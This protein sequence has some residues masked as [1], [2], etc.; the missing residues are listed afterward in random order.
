MLACV[1]HLPLQVA[2]AYV[3][4]FTAAVVRGIISRTSARE[5][6]RP[7]FVDTIAH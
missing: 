2:L 3:A 5:A 7:N 4:L 1:L 6:G